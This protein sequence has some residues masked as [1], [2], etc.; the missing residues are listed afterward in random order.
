[1]LED[2]S[3][4]GARQLRHT[5]ALHGCPDQDHLRR[6]V[7]MRLLGLDTP[8]SP[9]PPQPPES[10]ELECKA[11]GDRSLAE[12]DEQDEQLW[13]DVDR[14]LHHSEPRLFTKPATQSACRAALFRTMQAVLRRH[15]GLHYYQG[16]HDLTAVF[17]LVC[18]EEA[19]TLMTEAVATRHLAF[20]LTKD[21]DATSTVLQLLPP[22]L[23]A[24]A[25]EAA[26][27]IAGAGIEIPVFAMSWVLTW[28]AH[29]LYDGGS[30]ASRLYD[31]LLAVGHPLAAL[32]LGAAIV[33]WRLPALQAIEEPVDFGAVH[34]LLRNLPAEMPLDRL[35]RDA[36]VLLQTHPPDGWLL[37]AAGGGGEH[38]AAVREAEWYH[39][40]HMS[41]DGLVYLPAGTAAAGGGGRWGWGLVGHDGEPRGEAKRRACILMPALLTALSVGLSASAVTLLS[42]ELA[43]ASG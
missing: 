38:A 24:V 19:G 22:L 39:A 1:M 43:W 35:C 21:M 34:T 29:D 10:D 15:P 2:R 16:F 27:I 4:A 36:L 18:G 31:F 23:R 14:S 41:R 6:R 3:A 26:A 28:F 42:S 13:L 5:I 33:A 32:Y 9:P 20:A 17:L 7:W 25:P 8:L 30:S 11:A 40:K 12:Q 37:Q